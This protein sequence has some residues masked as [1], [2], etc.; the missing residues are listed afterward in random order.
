[1]LGVSQRGPPA[2]AYLWSCREIAVNWCPHSSLPPAAPQNVRLKTT[3]ISGELQVL[4]GKVL[5]AIFYEVEYALDPVNG[6]WLTLPAFSSTRGIVITGLTRG[7]DYYVR[8]RAVASGQNRGP[9]SDIAT[10]MAQ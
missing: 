2:V 8:V 4:L 6:P 7:K 10:A 3:G 5:R 1:M 9:W